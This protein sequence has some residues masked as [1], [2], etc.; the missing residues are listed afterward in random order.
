MEERAETI[1]I[2]GRGR[3]ESWAVNETDA[4]L[5]VNEPGTR[6]WFERYL[7]A[8]NTHDFEGFGAYYAD[9]VQFFGRATPLIGRGA[10]LSFFRE[11][12]E[13][14]DEQIALLSFIG[15]ERLIAAEVMISLV[16]YEDWPESPLGPL[17]KGQRL[18]NVNF[19]IYDIAEGRF[20]RIRSAR[21][22]RIE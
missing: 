18:R 14:V 8:F 19:A 11:M 16:P 15:N 22:R 6:V 17:L 20:V 12:A 9:D 3:G 10:V 21:F 5:S 2:A 7:A 4:G 1:S 13:R